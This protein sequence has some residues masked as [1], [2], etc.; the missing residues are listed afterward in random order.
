MAPYFVITHALEEKPSS[1]MVHAEAAQLH[2]FFGQN[3]LEIIATSLVRMGHI[4][5]GTAPVLMIV[6]H[7]WSKELTNSR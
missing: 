2:M 1:L 5:I 6:L 7:L 4:F 3:Q